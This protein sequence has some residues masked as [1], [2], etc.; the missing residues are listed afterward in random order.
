MKRT[1]SLSKATQKTPTFTTGGGLVCGCHLW[2]Q[3]SLPAGRLSQKRSANIQLL[4]PTASPLELKISV[5]QLQNKI[6]IIITSTIAALSLGHNLHPFYICPYL[7]QKKKISRLHLA[8][9]W[10]IFTTEKHNINVNN[11]F[12][13]R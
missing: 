8:Q 1:G 2:P 10:R 13:R 6:I 12:A 9:Q 5:A 7:S 4:S 11:M 3:T